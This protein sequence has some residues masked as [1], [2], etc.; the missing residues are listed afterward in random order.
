MDEIGRG[1]STYDGLA[2]AWAVARELGRIAAF[3]LFA[4]HYFELT[5]LPESLPT[6]ANV[7]LDAIEHGDR[8]VFLHAVKD[9]A[10]SRSY[11]IQVAA[12]AGVPERV[13][14][15]GRQRLE[16]L[17]AGRSQHAV[18]MDE[19]QQRQI[20]L[21]DN[22]DSNPLVEALQDMDPDQLSPRQALEMLYSLKEI[23]GGKRA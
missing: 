7:H 6:A 15:E 8:I 1:T 2:L 22:H 5:E 18:R 3:T 17:E 21:F 12:L 10:A 23:A 16:E 11:G 4:T 9:G 20:D 19:N 13:L 14:R